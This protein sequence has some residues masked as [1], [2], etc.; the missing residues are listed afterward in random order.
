[1]THKSTADIANR[2]GLWGG[3]IALAVYVLN[4]GAWVG[5]ADEK[6]SDAE[7]VEEKQD[8]MIVQQAVMSTRQEAIE[9]AVEE[10]QQA[11]EDSKE[12]ILAAIKEAH[13]DD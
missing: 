10:N 7:T 8:E 4:I 11:I 12:E 9:K 2:V 3:M 5:A 13:K 1:M 6:F